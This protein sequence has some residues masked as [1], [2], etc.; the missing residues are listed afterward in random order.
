MTHASQVQAILDRVAEWET[1][2]A[3]VIEAALEQAAHMA[4]GEA[5]RWLNARFGTPIPQFWVQHEVGT[6]GSI[7]KIEERIVWLRRNCLSPTLG[8]GS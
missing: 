4:P 7:I 1:P 2:H 6:W 3:A 8:S 5:L